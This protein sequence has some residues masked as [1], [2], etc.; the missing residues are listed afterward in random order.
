MLGSEVLQ[1]DTDVFQDALNRHSELL[2][3]ALNANA[4]EGL[5]AYEWLMRDAMDSTRR[6]AHFLCEHAIRRDGE[7][8]DSFRLELTQQQIGEITAQTPVNVNR[9]LR[10]F[11]KEKLFVPSGDRRYRADWPE[12]RRLGHFDARYLPSICAPL[13]QG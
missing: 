10:S 5:I 9:V 12:L 7:H 1:V 11:E 2:S 3:L 4:R 13:S 8:S 6:A